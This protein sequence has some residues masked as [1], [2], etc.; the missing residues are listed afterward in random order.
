MYL[1]HYLVENTCLF[2]VFLICVYG[3]RKLVTDFVRNAKKRTWF[4]SE[5]ATLYFNIVRYF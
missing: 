2:L 4:N 3:N 1:S 5:L